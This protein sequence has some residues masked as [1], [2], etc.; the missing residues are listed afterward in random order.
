M[1]R[2]RYMLSV[3]QK[4]P[5][6]LVKLLDRMR[7]NAKILQRVKQQFYYF[8]IDCSKFY[9]DLKKY[10]LHPRKSLDIEF[11]IIPQEYVRHFIR[12]CW[13]GDGSVYNEKNRKTLSASYVS[14]SLSFINGI[15]NELEKA[16][17]PKRTIHVKQGKAPSYYFRFTGAQCIKLYHFLYDDV[18]PHLYLQ[19][20][21]DKFFSYVDRINRSESNTFKQNNLFN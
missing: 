14:G 12:G 13:D 17:L 8:N 15:L 3:G 4:D 6:I 21:Y 18:S 1:I 19:R 11:P 7:C 20:K 16:G 5:E 9:N 2:H 10:G